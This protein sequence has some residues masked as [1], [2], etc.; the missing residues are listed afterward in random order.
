M[1]AEAQELLQFIT[2]L[3]S[4]PPSPTPSFISVSGAHSNTRT[5]I[6]PPAP[7]AVI[8]QAARPKATDYRIPLKGPV[9]SRADTLP[10][11][12]HQIQSVPSDI[13]CIRPYHAY[14]HYIPFRG[15]F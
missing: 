3:A 7:P 14:L 1:A 5:D 4:R 6:L 13:I 12:S 11:V 9:A 8:S 10:T 15:S 2:R